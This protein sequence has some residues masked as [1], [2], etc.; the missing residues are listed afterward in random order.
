MI[1]K[2]NYTENIDKY[3]SGDLTGD[4]LREFNVEMA[5]NQDL[6]EEIKLHQEIEEAIQEQDITALRN[7]LQQVMEQESELAENQEFECVEEKN[8]NFDLSEEI[9]SFKEF[10]SPVNINELI[11]ISES[12]PKIHLA[13]HTVADKENIH[14]FY[15][16]QN[17]E[18]QASDEEFELTPMDEALFN[19]VQNALEEKDII[20]L[21]A[22][23]QQVSESIPAHERTTQ[24]IDEFINNEM[25]EQAMAS[26]EEELKMNLQLA[27]DIELYSELD[28]AT[29]ENDIM[30]LRANLEQISN[31]ETSTTRKTEEIDQYINN[32]LTNEE[33]SSFESELT[34]N[35]DLAAE[36]DLNKDID[37]ALQEEDIMGLRAKLENISNEVI[38]E[39]RKERSFA[40]I[41][42]TRM[43]I[44]AVA[45]SLMLILSIAGVISRSNRADSETELYSQ[46]YDTYQATGIFRSGDANLDTKLT[47]AL[48]KF[49]SQEYETAI[50]LFNEVLEQDVNNP[51]SN[52]YTGMALQETGKY[53]KAITSYQTVVKDKDNLF[54]EQ[55][56][57][58]IGLCYLQTENRKKA[59]KQFKQIANSESYYSEKAN[60]VLRKIKYFE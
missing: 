12:L 25:D 33:L 50:T 9:S 49:N 42:S 24:E 10:N 4:D 46:Y 47:K 35:I 48:T 16:E 36:L 2:S 32:E 52:F 41:P 53:K 21:R 19:D 6:E 54:V 44:A 11:N 31:T 29:A 7:N 51:V 59:Y 38:K 27:K 57:W 45:A 34:T 30:D 60:A 26:F 55:A 37:K 39:K 22:N 1:R 23:L 13:Q 5:I 3:L 40:A 43:A 18:A 15:K 28:K 17:E 14:Q 56:E 58:Y 20:D 8:F